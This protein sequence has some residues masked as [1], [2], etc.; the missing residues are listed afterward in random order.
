MIPVTFHRDQE[1]IIRQLHTNNSRPRPRPL[2]PL[3]EATDVVAQLATEGDTSRQLRSLCISPIEASISLTSKG[4]GAG[5]PKHPIIEAATWSFLLF[6]VC[7]GKYQCSSL[8]EMI[9]VHIFSTSRFSH[10]PRN[11]LNN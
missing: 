9:G 8:T 7:L 1:F 5:A 10:I 6:F 4:D 11:S 2:S 3:R